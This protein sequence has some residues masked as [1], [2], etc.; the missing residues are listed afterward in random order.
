MYVVCTNDA[1]HA[2]AFCKKGTGSPNDESSC[3]M[4]SSAADMPVEIALVLLR[5][6]DMQDDDQSCV[7]KGCL[8]IVVKLEFRPGDSEKLCF[9][10]RA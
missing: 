8:A 6:E 4:G 10:P 1:P 7:A 5:E 3:T 2:R 9:E